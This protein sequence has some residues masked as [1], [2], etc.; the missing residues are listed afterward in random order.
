[1]LLRK[2]KKV[3]E[4][5]KLRNLAR[6]LSFPHPYLAPEPWMQVNTCTDH[7]EG[8]GPCNASTIKLAPLFL[9][10]QDFPLRNRHIPSVPSNPALVHQTN[11]RYANAG[12]PTGPDP[13]PALQ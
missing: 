7:G 5:G 1:M 11:Q 12:R 9:D 8:E 4:D 3:V 6:R 2:I 10:P 13:R